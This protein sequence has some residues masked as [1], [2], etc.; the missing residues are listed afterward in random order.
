MMKKTECPVTTL[1]LDV[2]GVLLTNGWD[3]NARARAAELFELESDEVAERHHLTYD[4]YEAGK[5][6]LD[7]YLDRTVF[8]RERSFTREDFKKF[9]F[10]QSRPY[11][12]TIDLMRDL[13]ARHGLRV[14]VVSNEGRELTVHR[15]ATFELGD[16]VDFFISSCFVH[17]RKPDEDIYRMALDIAQVEPGEVAYVDDRPLFVQVARSLGI[18]GIIHRDTASTRG[19]LADLGLSL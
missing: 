14:G 1:F 7:A 5:L 13:K 3:R 8:Y 11:P 6:T 17:C 2:G 12:E 18:R 9:M 16:F 4:T 19:A 10:E 15:I